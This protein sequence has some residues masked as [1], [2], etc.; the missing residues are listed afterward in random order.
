[1]FYVV[2]NQTI[3]LL[4]FRKEYLSKYEMNRKG[5][6]TKSISWILMDEDKE[7]VI[8]YLVTFLSVNI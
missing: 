2:P 3:F 6:L 5:L 8:T 4:R 1:M 7:E